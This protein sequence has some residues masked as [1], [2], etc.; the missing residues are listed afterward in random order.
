[1]QGNTALTL[2]E[3]TWE[4]PGNTNGRYGGLNLKG[5]ARITRKMPSRGCTKNCPGKSKGD[6]GNAKEMFSERTREYTRKWTGKPWCSFGNL[7]Y[8]W[9]ARNP[10][11]T[12]G[13]TRGFAYNG[14]HGKGTG[15]QGMHE[16]TTCVTKGKTHGG[17]LGECTGNT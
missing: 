9:K 10:L 11:R 15:T 14:T 1:M 16:R 4:P 12:S 3:L 13:G 7:P 17:A 8:T 5:N 2:R 6:K